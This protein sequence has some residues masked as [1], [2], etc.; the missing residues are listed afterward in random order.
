LI[1]R[2]LLIKL[3]LD[4]N[5]SSFAKGQLAANL[6]TRALTGVVDAALSASRGLEDALIGFNARAEQAKMGLAGIAGMNLK[7]PWEEAKKAA[8]ELYAG[9][10]ED[11]A[12]TPAETAELVAFSQQIAGAYLA[13]GKNMKDLRQFTTQAVV[14]AKMLKAEGTAATDI[15]QAIQGRVG[16][17]DMFAA[18]IINSLGMSIKQF[19]AKSMKERADLFAKGLNNPTIRAAMA[20]YETQWD[21]VTSTIKDN[22]AIIL[23]KAGK[24]LFALI[25]KILIVT[26]QWIQKNKEVIAG[27]LTKA[28]NFLVGAFELLAD[29]IE[30]V[31]AVLA[32]MGLAFV[33]LKAKAIAAAAASLA[34]WTAAAAP[35]VIIGAS[36]AALLLLLDDYKKSIDPNFKGRSLFKLWKTALDDWLKP[37][38]EPWF[39]VAIKQFIKLLVFARQIML[40]MIFDWENHFNRIMKFVKLLPPVLV[41]RALYR[42]GQGVAGDFSKITGAV[43]GALG[44]ATWKMWNDP[45]AGYKNMAPLPPMSGG[46]QMSTP[47]SWWNPLAS[48][49][50]YEPRMSGGDVRRPVQMN[51]PVSIQVTTQPGQSNEQI[52]SMISDKIDE[53]WEASMQAAYAAVSE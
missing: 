4:V 10:Q 5:E 34:A 31:T 45:E 28:V 49:G 18:N 47:P 6:I 27:K 1:L 17:K 51:A 37:K 22:I 46:A 52:A 39:V 24:P 21:G 44:D 8:D 2:E 36:I 12:K 32:I 7:L 41:G 15:K 38:D 48:F 33:A 13:A 40:D 26:G 35:F 25:K 29:N 23:G 53:H 11:A 43:G 20:E 3:G 14:A 42:V 16:V 50:E 19:N 30:A 9:L